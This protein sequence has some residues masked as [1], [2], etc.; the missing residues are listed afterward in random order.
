MT[1]KISPD[2]LQV[3]QQAL[4]AVLAQLLSPLAR[5]CLAKGIP[6]QAAEEVM[7]RAYVQAATD[8]CEGFNSSR[9]KSRIST[10]TG[11]TRRE[12][13]RLQSEDAPV[14]PQ[15]RTVATDVLTFWA[16]QS[17]YVNKKGMPIRLPRTGEAPSFEAL[18]VS[19]TR[20]VHPKSILADMVRLGLVTHNEKND[21][22]AVVDDIFVPKSDWPQM[23]GFI[24]TNVGDHL[25][26]SVDNV[27]QGG[28]KHFEQ[29]LL[30]DELSQESLEAAKSMITGQWR[31][32]LTQ[33]GPQ[34]QALMDQDKA[35]GRPQDRQLRIGLYSY[36]SAMSPTQSGPQGLASKESH[37]KN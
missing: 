10:M 19:V 27:L 31:A 18:A 12:V 34:L 28:G 5:L 29:A 36:M 7:R 4:L 21:T 37:E 20:D 26:A 33:L 8:D 6:I 35:L 16:S 1:S 14:L 32:L 13:A 30:A 24:G 3:E 2:G 17:E 23:V 15:T 9:L 25:Q 22:V 11:L